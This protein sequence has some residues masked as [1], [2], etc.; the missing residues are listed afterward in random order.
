MNLGKRLL[1]ARQVRQMSQV[2]V[3]ELASEIGGVEI[4]QPSYQKLE[5]RGSESSVYVFALAKALR[6]NPEWLQTGV[7]ESGLSVDAWAP[8][9]P[10]L[11]EEE[12]AVIRE[13]RLGT[14]NNAGLQIVWQA[15][16][17][18]DDDDRGN[19]EALART[20]LR[21]SE[22]STK[23]TRRKTT[24]RRGFARAGISHARRKDKGNM[25]KLRV[26]AGGSRGQ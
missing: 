3:C 24:A 21:A 7:G 12:N 14:R 5:K 13:Y 20:I 10:G 23:E 15:W 11:N 26:R 22:R 9:P 16:R 4:S 8:L 17:H 19:I 6:I 2:K 18:A 25:Q 1:Q